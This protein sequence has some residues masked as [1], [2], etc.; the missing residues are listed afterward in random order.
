MPIH[1]ERPVR[2]LIHVR[3]DTGSP[4]QLPTRLPQ[5]CREFLRMPAVHVRWS[6]GTA[7][8]PPDSTPAPPAR[9]PSAAAS[10]PRVLK[11]TATDANA[12]A[13]TRALAATL[14]K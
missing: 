1:S 9:V 12:Q 5:R 11:N 13:D 6:A 14:N 8:V 3:H 2:S 10:L 7:G 4:D